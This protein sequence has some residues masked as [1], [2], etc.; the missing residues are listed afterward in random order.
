MKEEYFVAVGVWLLGL[1]IGYFTGQFKKFKDFVI[2]LN[3]ILADD[4]I[5]S[6]ELKT[7]IRRFK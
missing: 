6:D 7:I 5:T 1:L 2:L 4:R 3:D